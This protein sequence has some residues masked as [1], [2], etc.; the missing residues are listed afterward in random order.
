MYNSMCVLSGSCH[1]HRSVSSET[2]DIL[3]I[4]RNT[5]ALKHN[6]VVRDSVVNT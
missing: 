1:K 3:F 2:G 5:E 4:C 6:T